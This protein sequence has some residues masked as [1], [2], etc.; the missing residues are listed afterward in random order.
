MKIPKKVKIG[1]YWWDVIYK[2]VVYS[3]SR[4]CYGICEDDTFT[5]TLS[6]SKNKHR[7]NLEETFIHECLHAIEKSANMDLSEELITRLSTN[8]YGFL[9]DNKFID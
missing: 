3:D 2:D 7:Q 6:K 4:E 9:K 8:I 1:A 5:I